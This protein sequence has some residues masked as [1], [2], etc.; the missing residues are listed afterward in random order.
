MKEYRKNVAAIIIN[1]EHKIWL[2]ERA[3]K[4]AWGFPQGGIDKGETPEEAL[5][6]EIMEELATNEFD[7]IAQYPGT[8]K[9]DFPVD[10]EF[11][12]WTYAGQEQYYFLIKLHDAAKIDFNSHPE[13]IEFLTYKFLSFDEIM[14]MD[15]TFK[16]EVYQTALNYFKEQGYL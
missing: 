3:D 7:L 2:G 12:T 5:Y 4:M 8:L 15:F 11:P 14:K 9:Y 10:M 6:R 13:E 1:S 16:T